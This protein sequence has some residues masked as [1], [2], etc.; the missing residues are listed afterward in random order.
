MEASLIVFLF[1]LKPPCV[2]VMFETNGVLHLSC[3][4][5]NLSYGC[6]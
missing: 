1:F 3:D 5:F 4:I 6:L 2:V